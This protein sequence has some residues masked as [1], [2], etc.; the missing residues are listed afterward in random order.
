[1]TTSIHINPLSNSKGVKLVCELCA[2]PAD[3]DHQNID[4]RGI[5]DKICQL[6]IP[7][8]TPITVLGSEEEREH[9]EKQTR[10]RQLHLVQ[11][12][13]LEAHKLLFEGQYDLAIPAALQALRFS[14]SVSSPNSI[15]LVPSYL[16]LGEASIGLKQYKQ[17]EDY[18]SLAKW[19]ILKA[20]ECENTIRSQLHRNF[21]LLYTSQ[22]QYEKALDQLA[23]DVNDGVDKIY[24]ISLAKTPEDIAV[25]GGYFQLGT[26]FHHQDRIDH[27]AA[28]F[29]KV[30][31]IW[32]QVLKTP[33][34]K[35]DAAQ[36]AEAVQMLSSIHAFRSSYMGSPIM[37][38]EVLYTLAQVYHASLKMDKAK[39]FA[40]K[41]LDSFE[42][43]LGREHL[44]SIEVRTY[45]GSLSVD[46]INDYKVKV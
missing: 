17:A 5:H 41:A 40:T 45:L 15:N 28:V 25:T 36:M 6:L 13:K 9:R 44:L 10:S 33:D 16:L 32:K 43:V 3:E 11:I 21:G 14:M 35:L 7:L 23:L 18:L 38:A 30:V 29:D 34:M 4:A 1:M 2:K 20:D 19:A 31:S 12:T 24:Y 37:A 46:A 8:R 26:V 22:G 42:A 27:A 39:E